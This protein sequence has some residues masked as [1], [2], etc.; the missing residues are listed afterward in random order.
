M[1]ASSV[2]Y[3][4]YLL[5]SCCPCE[6]RISGIVDVPN[7]CATLAIPDSIFDGQVFKF[8]AHSTSPC[9]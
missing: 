6:G 8:A 2:R 5:L 4:I 7:A 9:S 1:D 3:Q